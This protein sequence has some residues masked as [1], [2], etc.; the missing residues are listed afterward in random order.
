MVTELR[1]PPGPF[2]IGDMWSKILNMCS[3]FSLA[4]S[5]ANKLGEI[6]LALV[7]ITKELSL[8]LRVNLVTHWN[9]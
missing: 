4:F 3:I 1:K 7:R 6:N 9:F 8:L 2:Q 5:R